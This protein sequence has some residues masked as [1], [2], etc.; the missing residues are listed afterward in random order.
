MEK[1]SRY[2]EVT[3]QL[4]SKLA[5]L[6]DE[7]SSNTEWTDI[8]NWLGNLQTVLKQYPSPFM[9]DKILLSKRLNQCINPILP[10]KLHEQVLNIHE[11]LYYNMVASIDND[12]NEYSKLFGEEL[13]SPLVMQEH[14]RCP[15]FPT[16][17]T[18]PSCSTGYKLL[19]CSPTTIL[20]WAISSSP[21]SKA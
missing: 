3:E 14:T 4:N 6:L 18:P 5:T 12:I 8:Y 9:A 20:T 21:C 10:Q 16:S 2:K 13:G 11:T 1:G 15:S 7:F 17:P 19:K